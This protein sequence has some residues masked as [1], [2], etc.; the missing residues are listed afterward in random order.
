MRTAEKEGEKKR[1]GRKEEKKK[2]KK[3]RRKDA[4]R[5]TKIRREMQAHAKS[6]KQKRETP[7]HGTFVVIATFA[8]H[9]ITPHPGPGWRPTCA[10]DRDESPR[11]N[12]ETGGKGRSASG[13]TEWS[14]SA[15]GVNK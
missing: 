1:K 13:C 15:E 3:K 10:T 4:E 6:E 14:V 7:T 8:L 5:P 2:S 9:Q 11:G 12:V